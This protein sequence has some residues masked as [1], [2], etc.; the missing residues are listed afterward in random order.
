MTQEWE[1][2]DESVAAF[3]FRG[4]KST[5]PHP[6]SVVTAKR[7]RK[8]VDSCGAEELGMLKSLR[9]TGGSFPARPAAATETQGARVHPAVQEVAVVVVAVVASFA[10]VASA[11]S[12]E[13]KQ[14]ENFTRSQPR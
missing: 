3:A 7:P 8:K 6:R 2:P 14:V 10:V 5:R 11:V 1:I 4:S 13:R 12:A 9:Q